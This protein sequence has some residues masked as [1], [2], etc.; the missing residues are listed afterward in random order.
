M[1]NSVPPLTSGPTTSSIYTGLSTIARPTTSSIYTGL[2]NIARPTALSGTTSQA[3]TFP[4]FTLTKSASSA[5][6]S[7][8]SHSTSP[9]SLSTG[10][11]AGVGIAVA[12]VV[13]LLLVAAVFVNGRHRG[14]Q[15]TGN[16]GSP[17]LGALDDK[18]ELE[19]SRVSE[20]FEG[21]REKPELA[22]VAKANTADDYCRSVPELEAPPPILHT[23]DP[24]PRRPARTAVSEMPVRA[25][26][27]PGSI[28]TE[29]T[30]RDPVELE[31]SSESRNATPPATPPGGGGELETLRRKEQSLQESIDAMQALHRLQAEQAELQ[32]RIR[33]AEAKCRR[34]G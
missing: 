5:N 12:L 19:G 2:S 1:S 21:L 13:I 34:T 8:A 20:R 22:A 27:T 14:R 25:Q 18:P 4:R 6:T 9:H 16:L 30:R 33:L 31:E 28:S 24:V 3:V 7:A 26:P 23:R 15:R 32:E 11:K 29:S 10:V 17:A